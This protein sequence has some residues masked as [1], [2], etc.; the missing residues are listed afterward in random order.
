MFISSDFSDISAFVCFT[1]WQ[2]QP[3]I[4][5]FGGLGSV[6]FISVE[7]L[8]CALKIL[9]FTFPPGETPEDPSELKST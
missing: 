2:L 8:I 7:C 3:V 1:P 6:L 4:S 9:L 5:H